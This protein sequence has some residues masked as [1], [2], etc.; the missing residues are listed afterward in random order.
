MHDSQYTLPPEAGPVSYDSLNR[1][2]R[3]ALETIVAALSEAVNAAGSNQS[4][5]SE[6]VNR[7]I[8]TD[9]VSRLIFVSGEP[10]SGK[11]S[12]YATLRYVTVRATG[13]TESR[14]QAIREG[15]RLA[16]DSS[17]NTGINSRNGL[18]LPNISDFPPA[19]VGKARWL[20]PLPVARNTLKSPWTKGQNLLAAVLVRIGSKR[21]VRQ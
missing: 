12:L 18:G 7:A 19:R 10:G 8:D 2:Q 1:S 14:N 20:E 16:G 17:T 6:G 11:S 5:E 21:A 3:D 15:I 4:S 9:R 13:A